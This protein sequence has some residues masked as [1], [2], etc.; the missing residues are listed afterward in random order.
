MII[1]NKS[2]FFLHSSAAEQ[3]VQHEPIKF[4]S[5]IFTSR[6]LQ[7][8]I[9]KRHVCLSNIPVDINQLKLYIDKISIPYKRSNFKCYQN[10]K[11]TIIVE[12]D[13]DISKKNQQ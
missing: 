10:D 9:D 5:F 6:L 8:S 4:Q 1:I 2:F 7:R 3:V 11:R 13:E 12:Y